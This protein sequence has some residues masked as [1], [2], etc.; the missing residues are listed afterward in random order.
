MQGSKKVLSVRPRQEDYLASQGT[1]ILMCPMSKG[2]G[3][4]SVN[5]ISSGQAKFESCLSKQQAGIQVLLSPVFG[6]YFLFLAQ[7]LIS[8]YRFMTVVECR[9][10]KLF[11]KLK[12]LFVFS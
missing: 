9:L 7:L 12:C 8:A 11:R 3:K 4:L 6:N 1:F 5:Q 10:G 2:P